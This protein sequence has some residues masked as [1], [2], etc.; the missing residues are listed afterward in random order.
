MSVYELGVKRMAEQKKKRKMPSSFTILFLITIF[1]AILT[2]VIP[3]GQYE[4]VDGNYVPGS[5]HQVEQ[6]PQGIWNVFL[7]PIL[8]MLGTET[9]TGAIEVSMFI[10]FI[11]GF[12]GVVNETGAIDAGISATI[13]KNEGNMT[14]LI[15]ILMFIFALGGST[16]GMAEETIPFYTLLIPLMVSVGLDSLVA[17]AT[18]LVGSGLGVLSSTINPFATGIASEMAGIS[19]ADGIVVRIVF[20]VVTYIIGATYVSRYANKVLEDK[21]NSYM[22]E[23]MEEQKERFTIKDQMAKLTPQRRNVLILFGLTFVIMLLSLIPW[24][25]L[26]SSWTLFEDLHQWIMDIPILGSLIGQSALPLGH[27]YLIE[28]TMLFF[29]MSVIIAI[30]YG[31][32]ESRYVESFVTGAKDL[33]DV[34]LIV[35]VARGIQVIMNDGQ[36]TATVLHWG[37]MA[38]ADLPKGLFIVLMYLFYI[39]M[40][41]LIPSTSGLAAATMGIMGPLGDFAGV[42]PHLIVTAYQ[43]A[44]G[45][46]N[47]VTP[48]FGVIVGALA[49]SRIEITTW[50]KFMAKLVAL[51]VGAT[52]II[53]VISAYLV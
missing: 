3:A 14:R 10:L 23:Q 50:W 16:F 9:T 28:I 26:N 7:A 20:F 43:A 48:T 42:E 40:T 46:V 11:G 6:T 47:L 4:I 17:V 33:F 25:D 38:L 51:I 35:A 45:V 44:S 31:I 12:L 52:I 41:F 8:G 30:F 53:L 13:K 2:W 27:W 29:L 39:P 22:Y 34:A 24:S 15:W 36:I 37:E 49:I 32:D 21:R 5:Y 18:I 1:I 19:M